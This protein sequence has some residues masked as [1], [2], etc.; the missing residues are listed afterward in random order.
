MLSLL[1]P[2]CG[3]VPLR[4]HSGC[5][6]PTGALHH[7]GFPVTDCRATNQIRPSRESDSIM[8]HDVYDQESSTGINREPGSGKKSGSQKSG[9]EQELM[10]KKMEAAG[11]PGAPHKAL[12]VLVGDWKAEVK[13]WMDSGKPPEV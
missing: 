6:S 5:T 8:K 2:R 3:L 10:M 9:S 7:S 11:T 13:C 1:C 4:S 12:G